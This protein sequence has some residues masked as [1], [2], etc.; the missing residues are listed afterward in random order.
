MVDHN[1]FEIN[2]KRDAAEEALSNEQTIENAMKLGAKDRP[3]SNFSDCG[4]IAGD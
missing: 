1:E 2:V 3:G 4:P